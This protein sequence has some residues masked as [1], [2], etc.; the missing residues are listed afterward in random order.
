M[1]K[2]MLGHVPLYDIERAHHICEMQCPPCFHE[3]EQ[4][5]HIHEMRHA[6]QIFELGD[7]IETGELQD[8][9]EKIMRE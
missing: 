6:S 5:V 4:K 7:S 9:S 1:P 2:E 3:L 8:E